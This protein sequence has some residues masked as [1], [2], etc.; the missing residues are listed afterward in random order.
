MLYIYPI[1][2]GHGDE[3]ALPVL[4]RNILNS[5]FLFYDFKIL[6]PYRLPKG[7]MKLEAEWGGVIS[8]VNDRLSAECLDEDDRGL[9]LVVCD[10][11]D[12][13]LVSLKTQIDGFV[14]TTGHEHNFSFVAAHREYESWFL[15]AAE[16]FSGHNDCAQ[17]VVSVQNILQIS[18]AKGYFER[19]I[20]KDG[21]FYSETVDQPKFSAVIDFT[22]MPENN[23][24]SL[25]RLLDILQSA[26]E[27]TV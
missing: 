22:L 6:H 17:S 13:C 25:K 8:L 21:R 5:R 10:A 15:A 19:N 11:D 1:V 18:D 2:E 24:R 12:D 27:E 16:S 14:N 7:K 26:V 9:I 23:N 4:L 20:L 3:R